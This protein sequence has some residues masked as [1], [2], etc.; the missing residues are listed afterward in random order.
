MTL[1]NR[2][3][4]VL[5]VMAIATVVANGYSFFSFSR[6]AD[7][8]GKANPQMRALADSMRMSMIGITVVA[9]VIGL[10]AFIQIGRIVLNL[11]G[12]E[13]QYVSDAVRRIAGGDLG[14]EL[15]VRPGD[16]D[17]ICAAVAAMQANL[18]ETVGEMR[19]ASRQL[20]DAIKQ[21]GSMTTDIVAGSARQDEMAH[22]TAAGVNDL[23]ESVRRVVAGAGNVG[24]HVA[25]SL[26]QT[27]TANES[28]SHMI[29]EISAVEA[30][31]GDIATTANEFIERTRAITDMTREVR[32]I[33]DQTNLLALNAAI[34]AARAGEQGR[35]FA[36]VADEVRKL[37]EK[38]AA[39][40]AQI[41]SVTHALGNRSGEVESAIQRGMASL[42]TSQEYLEQVAM[43][44]GDSNH[45]VK[46]TTAET[47]D[48]VAALATQEEASN[49]IAG[50]ID[51]IVDMC[52]EN[53]AALERA[54][55]AMHGLEALAGRLE[56]AAA[57]FN[58]DPKAA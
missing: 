20:D 42:A 32:D 28:L 3:L 54:A 38:S 34:E 50:H 6:L 31:V 37:A 39:A 24:S 4:L 8:A 30:A 29:G 25:A 1:R 56:D 45:A 53:R 33:A 35:G 12:G 57:R 11:L 58:L 21:I 7:E 52:T 49:R 2:L 46:K 5:A 55:S 43:A 27:G 51:S 19:A 10:A 18:R 48:I 15:Q 36:V 22:E 13:P 41:D 47:D 40:A 26:D 16:R 14:V 9:A 23:A 17:S 44:L